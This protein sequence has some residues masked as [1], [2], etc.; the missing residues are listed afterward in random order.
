MNWDK[1]TTR[2]FIRIREVIHTEVNPIRRTA[3][4]LEIVSPFT[5]DKLLD[6]PYDKVRELANEYEWAWGVP[7]GQIVSRFKFKGRRFDAITNAYK[8]NAGQFIDS[9][10][11]SKGTELD[12][13]KNLN[14][15]LGILITESTPKW[16]FW[17]KPLT[18]EEKFAMVLDMPI[19][20]V[21]PTVVFFC[22]VWEKL[23]PTI[24]DYLEAVAEELKQTAHGLSEDGVG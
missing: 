3:K 18:Q 14:M 12:M 22:K 4:V 15:L 9:T 13:I 24:P 10:E 1:I 11:F 20:Y 5:Y 6:A 17:I 19:G 16:K 7:K 23:L 2:D 21:Y 8:I